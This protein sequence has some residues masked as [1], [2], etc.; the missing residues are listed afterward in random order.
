M[1]I[2]RQLIDENPPSI[3]TSTLTADLFEKL[4]MQQY[5]AILINP[6]RSVDW[7]GFC[8]YLECT[9]AGEVAISANLA[10]R[11]DLSEEMHRRLILGLY[12]HECAHRVCGAQHGH[13]EIFSAMVLILY[14]RAGSLCGRPLYQSFTLYDIDEGHDD[15]RGVPQAITWSINQADELAKSS[16]S[17]EECAASLVIRHAEWLK[18]LRR[19][20]SEKAT[21]E[22]RRKQ[23][24]MKWKQ[25]K[26]DVRRWKFFAITV[27]IAFLAL[28][29]S[30]TSYA[31]EIE[32]KTQAEF[33]AYKRSKMVWTCDC[34]AG[35]EVWS[36][37]SVKQ[38]EEETLERQRKFKIWKTTNA[39]GLV[40]SNTAQYALQ[41]LQS[42]CK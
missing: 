33:E 38:V 26:S 10:E 21:L 27:G 6:Q 37:K 16:L 35:R 5:P 29:F 13:G 42:G 12:L 32:Q 2:L 19:R 25:L 18:E 14:I 7:G 8:S 20:D 24:M 17:A 9:E 1:K 4:K 15:L 22:Y 23:N 28:F 34:V 3:L 41:A 11:T 36:W 30:V 39:P 31:E 40:I